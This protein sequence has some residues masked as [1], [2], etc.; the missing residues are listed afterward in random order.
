M[1]PR[2]RDFLFLRSDYGAEYSKIFTQE[3]AR[4]GI[5][6]QEGVPGRSQIQGQAEVSIKLLKLCL[7]KLIGVEKFGGR[8]RWNYLLP[9]IL[10]VVN[11]QHPYQT[12]LSRM[13]LLFS[14]LYFS[15]EKLAMENPVL[16]Q[17]KSLEDIQRTR[18]QRF[19]DIKMPQLRTYI[20]LRFY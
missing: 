5:E 3:L 15:N 8:G 11:S 6:H 19:M 1:Y 14:P 17:A 20:S 7:Q 4:Y 10:R 2:V 12:T 16:L 9:H 13:H 18:L